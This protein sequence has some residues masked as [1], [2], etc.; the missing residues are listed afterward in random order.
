MCAYIFS[1]FK[2]DH[3]EDPEAMSNIAPDVQLHNYVACGLVVYSLRTRALL[4]D[5]H[6]DLT[7]D[8]TK[9]RAFMCRPPHTSTSALCAWCTH[10]DAVPQVQ[11]PHRR[12]PRR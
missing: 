5:L 8:L 9:F 11:Q 12:G 2:Q 4:W 7:T 6:L 1:F 10:N 3:Y